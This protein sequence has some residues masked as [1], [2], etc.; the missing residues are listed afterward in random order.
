MP[1]TSTTDDLIELLVP[2][3]TEALGVEAS[4]QSEFFALGGNSLS[5]VAIADAVAQRY[6]ACPGIEVVALQ[7]TFDAPTLLAMAEF[8]AAFINEAANA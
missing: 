7:A 4:P 5:A 2:V 6:S 1:P 3:W 8:V